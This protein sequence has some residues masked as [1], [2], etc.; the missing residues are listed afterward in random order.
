[1]SAIMIT[2][3]D[4]S[5]SADLNESPAAQQILDNL[6]IEFSGSLWGEEIY[7]PIPVDAASEADTRVDVEIG[8]LAY[9]PP[10]S[11]FCIFYGPTPARN[12]DRP[13]PSARSTLSAALPTMRPF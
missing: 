1:M 8:T 4:I 7:G 6:P 5:L 9:W 10:G 13:R 3:N 11:T 12:C 2:V